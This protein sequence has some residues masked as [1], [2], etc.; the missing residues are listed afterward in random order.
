MGYMGISALLA[1]DVGLTRYDASAKL[2]P[3][4]VVDI[5]KACC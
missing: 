2:A 5:V 3:W 4:D 1:G